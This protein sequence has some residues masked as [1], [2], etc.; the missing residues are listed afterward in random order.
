VAA[1]FHSHPAG[2]PRKYGNAAQ[3]F[4]TAPW[5]EV[6]GDKTIVGGIFYG[7]IALFLTQV[8]RREREDFWRK[9]P[10]ML[11]QIIDLPKLF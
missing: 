4:Q 10:R 6:A 2:Q 3:S 9:S 7:T 8:T 5:R 1:D 11:A